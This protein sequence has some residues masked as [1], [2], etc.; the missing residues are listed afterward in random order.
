MTYSL[1]HKLGSDPECLV[2]S[3]NSQTGVAD[4]TRL[5]VKD[6]LKIPSV[7]GVGLMWNHQEQLKIG[8]DYQW[9]KWA[10]IDFPQYSLRNNVPEYS[11]VKGLF[12]DMHKMTFGGEYC[13]NE[14]SR[15]F[16]GRIHYRGGISYATPYLKINGKEGPKAMSVS[17]GF[18][19]PITNNY[20][21]RS[22]LNISGQ[23]VNQSA[24]GFIKENSFRI[25][26]GFT[27]NE[28]WFA[29]FKVE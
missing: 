15:N 27:F 3:T 26:V 5:S 11:L 12:T 8:L 4:S 22:M 1:G 19:I 21:N 13:K 20:N 18:G 24:D 14:R 10:D 2:I 25:N 7:L 28:R 17:A 9:Q 16:F 29:K 23:W 6:G